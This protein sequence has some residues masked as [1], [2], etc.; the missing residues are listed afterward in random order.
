MHVYR[1]EVPK[2]LKYRNTDCQK[3][4]QEHQKKP[5]FYYSLHFCVSLVVK[6]ITQGRCRG[7]G[8]DTLSW[9]RL[10]WAHLME[11]SAEESQREHET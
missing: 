11:Q 3:V 2:S 5:S 7:T 4:Y 9:V 10:A 6:Y 1:P 8:M